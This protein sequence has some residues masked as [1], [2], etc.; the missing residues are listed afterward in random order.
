MSEE[1]P[2]FVWRAD[3]HIKMISEHVKDFVIIDSDQHRYDDCL[4]CLQESL[5]N[6]KYMTITNLRFTQYKKV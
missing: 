4:E 1:S 5:Q 2:E 6:T 3:Y